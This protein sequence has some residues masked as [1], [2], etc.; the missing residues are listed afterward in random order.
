M[1]IKSIFTLGLVCFCSFPSQAQ[2]QDPLKGDMY[3]SRIVKEKGNG[4]SKYSREKNVERTRPGDIL[5]YVIKYTNVS[6]HPLQEIE[7]LGPIPK[8]TYLLADTPAA[9]NAGEMRASLDGGKSYG[10]PPLKKK[11]EKDGK[12]VEVEVPEK[13]WTH[14]KWVVK[15]LLP[16]EWA[17]VRYWVTVK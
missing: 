8:D 12:V 17:A 3:V 2:N 5:E 4:E 9:R 7:I 10:I 15:K 6:R 1:W 13:E 14:L 11:I 16:G